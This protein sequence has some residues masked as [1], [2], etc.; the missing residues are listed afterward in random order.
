MHEFR[1]FETVHS[2]RGFVIIGLAVPK[3]GAVVRAA[4]CRGTRDAQRA[5]GFQF[6]HDGREDLGRLDIERDVLAEHLEPQTLSRCTAGILYS[7]LLANKSMAGEAEA[8]FG[9]AGLPA[10]ASA[11]GGSL[12]QQAVVLFLL[13]QLREL[14]M[15]RV[16]RREE[17]F[18]AVQDWRVRG[19][20]VVVAIDVVGARS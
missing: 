2:G 6:G 19:L 3:S 12:V 5:M 9:E 4:K 18:F 14:R 15:E 13:R 16:I 20:G 8:G 1:R 11:D 10:G 17:S 7:M